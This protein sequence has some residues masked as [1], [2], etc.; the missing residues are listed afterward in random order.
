MY[1]TPSNYEVSVKSPRS[2]STLYFSTLHN[3]HQKSSSSSHFE[4]PMTQSLESVCG[5]GLLLLLL[6]ERVSMFATSLSK[7]TNLDS[8]C[9]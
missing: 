8:S 1:G 7:P 5:L 2:Y 9:V 3:A 6:L 4:I